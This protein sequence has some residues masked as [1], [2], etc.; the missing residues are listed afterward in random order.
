MPTSGRDSGRAQRCSSVAGPRTAPE[1]PNE[2]FI[3]EESGVSQRFALRSGAAT[4]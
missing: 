1:E 3:A 4:A 2:V